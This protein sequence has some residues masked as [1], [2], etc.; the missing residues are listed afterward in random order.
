MARTAD[1]EIEFRAS[2]LIGAAG[3]GSNGEKLVNTLLDH[4]PAELQAAL[5]KRIN[6][7]LD[8][9][10]DDKA[11]KS[12]AKI[13]GVSEVEHA[14]VRGGDRRHD[15]AVVTYVFLDDT[16]QAW[17]GCFPW[18]DLGESSSDGHVSQRDSLAQSTAAQEH[19]AANPRPAKTEEPAGEPVDEFA[20]LDFLAN[21]SADELIVAMEEHPERVDAIKAFESATRG[22][23]ARKTVLNFEPEP[24]SGD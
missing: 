14:H 11:M 24:E 17:K 19:L 8:S 16:G 2:D 6:P 22:E 12:I 23:K 21:A 7:E 20:A 10:L 4:Y 15:D 5:E 1:T 3:V 13:A 18:N 9:E